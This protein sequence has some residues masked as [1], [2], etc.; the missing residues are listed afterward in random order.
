MRTTVY[1][2]MDARDPL[3]LSEG[4]CHQLHIISYHPQVGASTCTARVPKD[5][6]SCDSTVTVP[7]VRVKLLESTRLLPLQSNNYGYCST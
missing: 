7:V 1:L 3:L 2:K 5:K 4:V 6:E